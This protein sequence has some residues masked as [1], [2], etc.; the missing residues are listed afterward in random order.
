M[1]RAVLL[2]VAML[3]ALGLVVTAA[4]A[5]AAPGPPDAPEYW[6]DSWHVPQLWTS[7]ARGQGITIAEIDTGVNASLPEL[8]GRVVAGH[9]FG[10]GGDGRIDREVNAFGH[11]TAMASIMVGRQGILGIT[12]LAPNSPLLPI[13]VPLSG[14]TGAKGSDHL[15][16]AIRWAVDHGG[17]IVSMSLGGARNPKTDVDSCPADEQSAIY[18][19][20]N[21]GAVLLA[22]SGNNG[23]NNNAVEEPGVCLGVISVGAVNKSGT[24]AAFSSRHPYLT[25]TAPG[26]AIAS[27]SRVA[28]T[29]YSGDGTSQATAIASAAIALVWS[30]YPTLTGRQVVTRVLAT[31]DHNTGKHDPAYGYGTIHPYRAITQN[32]NVNGPNAVYAAAD[33]F[34]ARSVA[35]AKAGTVAP[36]APIVAKRRSFGTFHIGAAPRLLAPRVV[37]GG[38]VALVGLLVVI[39]LAVVVWWRRRHQPPVPPEPESD[40]YAGQPPGPSIEPDGTGLEWRNILD[41]ELPDTHRDAHR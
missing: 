1:R 38:G 37:L 34:I 32:V 15:A 12:G 3:A 35:L 21:K 33:P 29:A 36:P 9:D 24:V 22:A 4:P 8:S 13:A 2:V 19:A 41:A 27:L 16:Q 6:F 30:K 10:A 17:K 7:G 23:L 14:T 20:L 39:A 28:G 26:V 40:P 31:L 25:M 11:G 18:Y 5:A